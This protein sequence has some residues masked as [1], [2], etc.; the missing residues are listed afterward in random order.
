M[1]TTPPSQPA[2]SSAAPNGATL[3]RRLADGLSASGAL[4]SAE[5]R[6]AVE[7]VPREV[8]VADWFDRDDTD[9]GTLWTPVTG[10]KA[11]L[12]RVYSDVTLVTQLD[13]HVVPSDVA[14]PVHGAPSSSSTLPGLV[15][16]ML[17]DLSVR[18]GDEVLEIGTGSG[19]STALLAQRLGDRRVT[20]VEIDPNTSARAA[21]A[22]RRAGYHPHLVVGDGLDGVPDRAPFT[23]VIATCSVRRVPAPWLD[24]ADT[25]AVILTNLSGWLYAY[26]QVRLTVH[27]PGHA[28]GAFLPG[29][30]SFMQ[31]RRDAPPPIDSRSAMAGTGEGRPT[32]LG[33]DILADWT[34]RFVVQGA[35]PTVQHLRTRVGDDSPYLD[36]LIATDGSY[37]T[38]LPQPDG[39]WRVRQGGPRPMWDRAERA[40]AAWRAAGSP[41][42]AA[43]RLRVTPESQSVHLPHTDLAWCL[44]E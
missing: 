3:R 27:G 35:L 20:S 4:R 33:P 28:T 37:A 2:T 5:W 17:E 8:F 38:L 25:G 15:V 13:G 21:T 26:G 18:D 1:N 22:L 9:R 29:H 6:A 31:A 30:V 14:D 24:Q 19:Y 10:D 40:V 44:P 34:G 43:F 11:A 42:T 12:D 16:G 23:R 36:H 7:A 41:P 32:S 39:G